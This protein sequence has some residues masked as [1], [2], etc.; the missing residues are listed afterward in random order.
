VFADRGRIT[1]K[2][3]IISNEKPKPGRGVWISLRNQAITRF[4]Q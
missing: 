4:A 1:C 2:P 3:E